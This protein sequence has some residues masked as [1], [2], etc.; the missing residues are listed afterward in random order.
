MLFKQEV[1]VNKTSVFSWIICLIGVSLVL[2]FENNNLLAQEE[3]GQ[4]LELNG[5]IQ[6]ALEKNPEIITARNRWH[7]AQEIIAARG[8]L[9]DP[10]FSYT[11]FVENVETRVGPQEQ[12]FGINQKFPFYGKRNLKAEAAA[13]ES[14]ALQATYKA[15]NQEVVRQVKKAF[16]NFFYLSKIIDITNNE[17]ELLNRIEKIARTKYET[18]KG[19]QQNVLKVHVEISKLKDKLLT[20]ATQ[21]Q[22]VQAMINRLLDRQADSSLEKPVQPEIRHFSTSKEDLFQI[23]QEK[24][25]ELR[26]GTALIEKSAKMFSL[27]K[28]EYYPDLT[29]GANY[30]ETDDG[31][32]SFD[33]NGQDAYNVVFSINIPIWQ[34]K[35]SSQVKSASRAVSAQK[36]MYE[37]TLNR[38]LFE[39]EDT[40]FKIQ[41]AWESYSLYKDV[42]TPQAEQSLKS[43]ES[44]YITGIV[45]FLDLLDAERVL[46]Q[47]QYGYW[48]SYTDYLKSIADMERAVGVDLG[49]DSPEGRL[50]TGMEK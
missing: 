43:A 6:E 31:P 16:Y 1:D 37:E 2:F 5:L 32:L 50:P 24:R 8:A 38:T 11:Y 44:G 4:G 27:A 48:K 35:L 36:S 19:N 3:I 18:G 21:R 45:S 7:S 15:V 42:L 9:P 13:K 34:A 40:Y 26:G 46:L 12:I 23:A 49:G 17:Q 33:D 47:I 10:R 29:V 22:T 14:D 20:L 25:P 39:V 41:T 30:I 28:K